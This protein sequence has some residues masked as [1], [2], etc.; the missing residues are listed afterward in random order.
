MDHPTL[1]DLIK[2]YPATLSI[3]PEKKKPMSVEELAKMEIP[4]ADDVNEVLLEEG[5]DVKE[6]KIGDE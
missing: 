1:S 5:D 3:H 6:Y 4:S 2:I